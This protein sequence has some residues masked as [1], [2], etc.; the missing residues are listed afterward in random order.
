MFLLHLHWL[1]CDFFTFLITKQWLIPTWLFL[2][3]LIFLLI[4]NFILIFWKYF[5]LCHFYE[6]V[7][8]IMI[9]WNILT[10][11]IKKYS[12]RRLAEYIIAVFWRIG[13]FI[14]NILFRGIIFIRIFYVFLLLLVIISYV[15]LLKSLNMSKSGSFFVFFIEVCD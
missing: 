3:N 9:F 15:F 8:I 7:K 10:W 13:G 6:I 12:I 1:L 2:F 11:L 14:K 5:L 4:S